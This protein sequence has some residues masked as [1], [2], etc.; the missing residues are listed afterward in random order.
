[1]VEKRR[2]DRLAKDGL[3]ENNGTDIVHIYEIFVLDFIYPLFSIILRPAI[4]LMRLA[5][6]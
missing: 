6:S 5:L 4:L 1:M 3:A 2:L